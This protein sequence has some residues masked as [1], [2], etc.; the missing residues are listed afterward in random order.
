[1]VKE[2]Q[3]PVSKETMIEIYKMDKESN[4]Y[5]EHK[6]HCDEYYDEIIR[7]IKTN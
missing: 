2:F 7:K 1:M 4:C 3:K 6:F 5:G